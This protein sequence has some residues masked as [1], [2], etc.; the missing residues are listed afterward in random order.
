MISC[1]SPS[2]IPAPRLFSQSLQEPQSILVPLAAP[3]G[4]RS[5]SRGQRGEHKGVHLLQGSAVGNPLPAAAVCSIIWC[6]PRQHRV[7]LPFGGLSGAGGGAQQQHRG[8]LGCSG[9]L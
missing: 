3:L 6:P 1:R 2:L 4:L 7:L 5:Q 9:V 8:G